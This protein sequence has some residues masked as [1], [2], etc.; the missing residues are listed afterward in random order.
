M[1]Q[2]PRGYGK[3]AVEVGGNDAHIAVTLE[4][5][6]WVCFTG[7]VVVVDKQRWNW[8]MDVE[9]PALLAG[10]ERN[11]ARTLLSSGTKI[12]VEARRM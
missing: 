8:N 6:S 4:L 5:S 3:E 1:P 2:L 11:P 9:L 10:Y 12:V 7:T